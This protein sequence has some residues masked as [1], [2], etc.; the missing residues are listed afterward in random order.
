MT[1]IAGYVSEG[2]ATLIADVSASTDRLSIACMP[3][4]IHRDG[5]ALIGVSG[6]LRFTQLLRHRCAGILTLEPDG[7]VPSLLRWIG[8]IRPILREAGTL[9][10]KEGVEEFT[11]SRMLV[12]LDGRL[13]EIDSEWQ[14]VEPAM[15]FWAIGSGQP[16]ALAVLE[17]LYR[18]ESPLSPM[19]RLHQAMLTA[20]TFDPY[21]RA[22]FDFLTD[23]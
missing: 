23:P 22:P 20:A 13:F 15:P 12:A 17:V 4:K 5:P 19:Q 3:H 18:T 7:P 21:V 8:A 14:I 11:D 16:Y 10:V 9:R 2:R 1:C 6:G